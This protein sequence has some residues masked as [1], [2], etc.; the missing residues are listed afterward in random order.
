M[1]WVSS[2]IPKGYGFD[3]WSGVY[4]R[5][6]INVSLNLSLSLSAFPLPFSLK[7]INISSGEDQKKERVLKLQEEFPNFI[8]FLVVVSLY[9]KGS[10]CPSGLINSVRVSWSSSVPPLPLALSHL[11]TY[12]IPK[13]QDPFFK[14]IL[15]IN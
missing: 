12:R 15:L 6:P 10:L 3:S 2:H 9:S 8:W 13:I 5:H 11:W 7:S 1:G 14:K 4:R